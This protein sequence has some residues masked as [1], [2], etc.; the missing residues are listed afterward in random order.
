[1]RKRN[2][3]LAPVKDGKYAESFPVSKVYDKK[4]V[5][6]GAA[7]R[8]ED[9]TETLGGSLRVVE[10][11]ENAKF[12]VVEQE[13]MHKKYNHPTTANGSIISD[14]N[15]LVHWPLYVYSSTLVT[16]TKY[17]ENLDIKINELREDPIE[18]Q[19]LPE[20]IEIWGTDGYEFGNAKIVHK[21]GSDL[22]FNL[23]EEYVIVIQANHHLQ[24]KLKANNSYEYAG[25]TVPVGSE[26]GLAYEWKFS[27]GEEN[28]EVLTL[29]TVVGLGSVLD[30][31]NIQ[32][33]NIGRYTCHVK[34]KWG[35]V[36]SR[37]IYVHV[38]RPGVIEEE[39][40]EI[41]G[42]IF[43]TGTTIFVENLNEMH[44]E[45]YTVFDDKVTWDDNRDS[46]IEVYWDRNKEEWLEE[47][48][49]SKRDPSDRIMSDRNR[50][51]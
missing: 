18:P 15:D 1:M 42:V 10:T 31:P 21:E 34:N 24:I 47:I 36:S 32:R 17:L 4:F 38:E 35:T 2:P 39:T 41:E 30:I 29:D 11:K 16:R 46:F 23:G 14:S 3:N 13:D 27:S 9:V 49:I 45:K 5:K 19:D 7:V 51:R 28:Y 37:T 44:D 50:E 22:A 43:P 25:G 33:G 20:I 40:R 8:E 12:G 26:A 6:D 48:S